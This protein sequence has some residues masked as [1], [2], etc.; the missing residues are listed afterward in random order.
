MVDLLAARASEVLPARARSSLPLQGTP[1][2]RLSRP[3]VEGTAGL[4]PQSA[5]GRSARGRDLRAGDLAHLLAQR[6]AVLP[7]GAAGCRWTRSLPWHQGLTSRASSHGRRLRSS[8]SPRSCASR[9]R[10]CSRSISP[11]PG[12]DA[13]S[14]SDSRRSQGRLPSAASRFTSR[15]SRRG[16]RSRSSSR[17]VWSVRGSRSSARA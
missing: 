13:R 5:A 1:Y 3:A 4:L 16:P 6:Q 7:P 8:S 10:A 15:G 2:G 14:T 11:T 9:L 17:R 12:A